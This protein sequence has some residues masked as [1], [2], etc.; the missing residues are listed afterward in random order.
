M[1][2]RQVLFLSCFVYFKIVYMKQTVI[3]FQGRKYDT[4]NPSVG[5]NFKWSILDALK[6][7]SMA[8]HFQKG[9]F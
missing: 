9:D 7:T 3:I 2:S 5:L 8:S 4:L 1:G 6:Q